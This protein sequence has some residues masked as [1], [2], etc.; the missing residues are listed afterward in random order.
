M[1]KLLTCLFILSSLISIEARA[2]LKEGYAMIDAGDAPRAAQF[3]CT[4][5]YQNLKK[6]EAAE[7]LAMCGRLLDQ[8]ADSLTEK[9][10]KKC[11]WKNGGD[12]A[13]MQREAE[14]LNAQ[15]GRGSF[16]YEHNILFLSYAGS[17]YKT[18]LEKYSGSK[19]APEAE[20][21][22]LLRQ[23]AAHPD[24]VIPKVNAFL[25]KYKSGEWNRRGLLLLA[26]VNED[27]WYVHKKWSWVLY[28]DK[29]GEDELLIKSEKYRQ[30]ALNIYQKLLSQKNT[31]EGK[32]AARE[33]DLL[34]QNREDGVLYSIVSDS[35][36]GTL[37]MWGVGKHFTLGK[38]P[39]ESAVVDAPSNQPLDGKQPDEKNKKVNQRW[40]N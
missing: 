40:S 28:N 20:F 37:D 33:Y 7:A 31:V 22:L 25:A 1:K 14:A 17:Q 4:Q 18:I 12:P 21:Y 8:L 19:Y 29:V 30:D 27:V 16:V 6:D 26:R 32:M 36:P 11:Y 15:Y 38:A 10:E 3:F 35:S 2:E 5:P 34:K 13:C 39:S 9:A 23:V 24:V